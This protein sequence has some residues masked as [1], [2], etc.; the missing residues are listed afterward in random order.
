MGIILKEAEKIWVLNN[1][2]LSS[3]DFEKIIQKNTII[4]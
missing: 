4:N 2:N 1:F 3:E